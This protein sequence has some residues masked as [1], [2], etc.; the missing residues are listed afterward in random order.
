MPYASPGDDVVSIID[1]EPTPLVR[2]APG[3]VHLALM[4]YESHP[5]IAML[6]KPYLPLAGIRIDPVLGAARL[7]RVT[8]L[9][10]LRLADGLERPLPLP[11]GVQVGHL[12]WA[13]DGRR[14]AFT[15]DEPDGIGVWVGDADD[16]T[17]SPVPG[18]RVRDVLGGEPLADSRTIRWSRDGQSLLALAA[19]AEKGAAPPAAPIEPHLEETAGKRSQMATFQDLL[20]T[21]SDED[22]FESLATTLPVRVN[23]VTGRREELGPPGLYQGVEESPD[24]AYLLVHRLRRPFSFRVPGVYFARSVEV[25]SAEGGL[26]RVIADLPVSDEVPRQ[27]VPTGPRHVSWGRR[28]TGE[29]AL[30]SRPWTAVIGGG[31]E[32][33]TGT[34]CWNWPRRSPATGA[35]RVVVSASLFL[36]G[37][38]STTAPPAAGRIRSRP[39]LAHHLA[40]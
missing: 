32:R 22:T 17:A 40:V 31:R 4:H 16:A 38:T 34:G 28:G 29:L 3:G 20:R 27:G 13:P 8:G 14:L 18:L 11:Q 23:P 35:V 36:G 6:A 15:V 30:E 33:K 37:L 12:V 7:R 10:V 21:T 19:P 1:A 24:G 5:P 39:P 25:W 26:E 2:L 9:S